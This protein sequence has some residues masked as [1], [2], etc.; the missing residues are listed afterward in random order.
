[1]TQNNDTILFPDKKKS[2]KPLFINDFQD[3]YVGARDGT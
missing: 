3:S 2:R 1:M